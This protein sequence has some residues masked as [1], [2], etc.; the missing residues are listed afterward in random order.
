MIEMVKINW[1]DFNV[2]QNYTN[3]W[4]SRKQARRDNKGKKIRRVKVVNSPNLG[5]LPKGRKK[6]KPMTFFYVKE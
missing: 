3:F 5:W 4:K 6:A 2:S 1:N